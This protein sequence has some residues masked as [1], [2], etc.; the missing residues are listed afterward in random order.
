MKKGMLI[1]VGAAVVLLAL[2]LVF[3]QKDA[4]T[5]TP[6][7]TEGASSRRLPSFDPARVT[8]LE[9]SGVRKA[10][11]QRD[12]AGWTV[13]DPGQPE[14]RFPAD[15]A[16]VKNAL[17]S[18][19][20]V[21]G[22]KFVTVETDRYAD[23]WMDSARA[24]KVRILLEGAPPMEWVLGK[25]GASTG[26]TYVRTGAAP[27]VFEHPVL[28]GWLWR[29]RPM[30][31]RDARLMRLEVSDI[32]QM[33]L[34]VGD[35]SPVT[36]TSDGTP[37]GWRLAEGTQVPEGF[38]FN[39]AV[40]ER[41]AQDLAAAEVEDQLVGERA[42]QAA[43]A[44]GSARDTVEARLKNGKAVALHLGR[45]SAP[46]S[47]DPIPVQLEGDAR[48]FTVNAT[49]AVRLRK[50]LTD[51]RDLRL[52]DFDTA[53]VN[54]LLL[55][56]GDTRLVVAKEGS[57]WALLEPK[58]APANF[59]LDGTQVE[60]LLVWLQRLEATRWVD[61]QVPEAQAGLERPGI[62]VEVSGE[63][64]PTQALRLGSAVP[65]DTGLVSEVYARGS[66]DDFTYAV[67][68]SSRAWLSQGTTL[69]KAP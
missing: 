34:R 10:T 59:T 60:S 4:S 11:L 56:E 27:D 57:A 52:L 8:G 13:W 36:V 62:L 51:L 24:Q 48:L 54:R 31:W 43:Q 5:E 12:G 68:G 49:E 55:Q 30:D 23:F 26:G 25:D 38:R 19:S 22:A 39:P 40:V 21:S 18:L 37:G 65:D 58:P 7:G 53:K 29:R 50:R 42:T 69:V 41:L 47:L 6:P 46:A 44:L 61:A 35:E 45:P 20:R 15:A 33:V 2:I 3:A 9:L 67:E 1:A 63:G 17:E 66:R 16:S 32:S 14:A 64:L 28:L